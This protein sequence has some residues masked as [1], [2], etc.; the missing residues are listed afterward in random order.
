MTP[1]SPGPGSVVSVGGSLGVVVALGD[2]PEG[3]L[4]VWY[5]E[6]EEGALRVRTVPVEYCVLVDSVRTYH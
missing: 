5:G 4:A 1:A 6:V 2:V 3:H